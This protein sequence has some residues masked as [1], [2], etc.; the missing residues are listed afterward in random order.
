MIAEKATDPIVWICRLLRVPRSSFY[1]WRAQAATETAT[2]ARRRELAAH[3]TLVF[4]AARGTYGC[5]RVAAHLN[6]EGVRC[7]VG[8]V[9]DLMRELG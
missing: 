8:L 6:R 4:K 1:A 9:A 2:A 7:S 3:V 5:G